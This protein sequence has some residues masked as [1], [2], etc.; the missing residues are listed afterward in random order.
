MM[1]C[2]PFQPRTRICQAAHYADN[3]V[4]E[5]FD[6]EIRRALRTH[7]STRATPFRIQEETVTESMLVKVADRFDDVVSVET[8]D[9]DQESFV[10]ADWFWLLDSGAVIVPMLV[11]AKKIVGAWDGDQ[12]WT[13]NIDLA[14]K[15]TIE[16]IASQ[17]NVGAQFCVYAPSWDERH[18]ELAC[19]TPRSTRRRGGRWRARS[20][21]APASLTRTA[22]SSGSASRPSAR[23]P[24]SGEP[25]R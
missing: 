21:G 17:W 5:F 8:F 22:A 11:Q 20:R 14:Q 25:P 15:A 4:A 2:N 9:K 12:D 13:V 18:R 3:L 19:V 24:G 6:L 7:H 10:G 23:G 16:S 1:R